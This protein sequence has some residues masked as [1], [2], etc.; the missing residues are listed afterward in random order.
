MKRLTETPADMDTSSGDGA[1]QCVHDATNDVHL[2]GS[3]DNQNWALMSSFNGNMLKRIMLVPRMK[4]A[5]SSTDHT[6]AVSGT[7]YLL[8]DETD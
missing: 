7:S 8:F 3:L 1:A 5:G 2:W 6:V 4:I